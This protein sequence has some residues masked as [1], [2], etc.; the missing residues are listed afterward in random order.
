MGY[1]I[2]KLIILTVSNEQL[3]LYL[4]GKESKDK[5]KP[6]LL[7]STNQM[8][9]CVTINKA[10]HTSKVVGINTNLEPYTGPKALLALHYSN[11]C[12]HTISYKETYIHI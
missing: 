8:L 5:G 4:V 2:V 12:T 3:P 10:M 11:T 7:I 6:N 9:H 1:Y